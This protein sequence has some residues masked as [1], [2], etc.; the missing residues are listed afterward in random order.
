MDEWTI[1]AGLQQVKQRVV[2]SEAGMF[3]HERGRAPGAA[4]IS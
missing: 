2:Q 1:T 3:R 4:R